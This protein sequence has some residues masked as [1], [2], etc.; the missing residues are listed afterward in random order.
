MKKWFF[1]LIAI[2]VIVASWFFWKYQ[3][4]TK[5]TPPPAEQ[6]VEKPIEK[7]APSVTLKKVSFEELPGW[8]S[9]D[10]KTSFDVF[11][12]SCKVFL[13]QDSEKAVGSPFIPMKVKDW[14]PACKAA[15]KLENPSW[16]KLKK[17]F[18]KWFRPA[19]FFDKKPVSGLF[20]GYYSPLL[21]GSLE[22][23]KQFSVPVY[24]MPK[25][26]ITV[27]LGIFFPEYLHKKIVG[28]IKGDQ[29]IPYY[30]REEINK[31]AIEKTAPV[32]VWLTNRIDRLFL[33][34]QGSGAVELPN[35]EIIYLGYEGENG[36]PYKSVAQVLINKGVM[37]K[38]NASMQAIRKYLTEN[39]HEMDE[40]LHQNKSFVF[41]RSLGHNAAYGA[42]GVA[43]IPEYSLAVD[44]KFI[45]LGTPIWLN[46]TRPDSTHDDK[47]LFRRLMIAQDTGGAIRGPVRGD[48]Y[49]GTGEEATYIAG[50]MKNKGIYW[51]LLPK[52]V[53]I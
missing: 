39:P 17:Y 40:V 32:V 9:P 34:I 41:F 24:G 6:P 19:Q 38:H 33:E 30:T 11:K 48:V 4:P 14:I 35:K 37:T 26:M 43:L 12:S 46:T 23:S 15:M 18:E 44:R 29:L 53:K 13:K 10:L 28:R 52:T 2:L 47:Q 36:A 8:P 5:I 21:E 1:L 42:Q 20:T 22:K 25:G 49:W 50:H 3:P 31:G 45:P 27:N 16:P 7:P 51:L